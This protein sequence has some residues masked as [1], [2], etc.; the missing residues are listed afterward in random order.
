MGVCW[1]GGAVGVLTI[2]VGEGG[3]G[4]TSGFCSLD[5]VPLVSCSSVFASAVF[6]SLV[7]I[8]GHG[9]YTQVRRRVWAVVVSLHCMRISPAHA[10]RSQWVCTARTV[11]CVR[12]VSQLC[13]DMLHS[14]I[15]LDAI[16]LR[17]HGALGTARLSVGSWIG[18]DSGRVEQGRLG[19][20]G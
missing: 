3:A 18:L 7:S 6:C 13:A 1:R 11:H 8:C 19:G 12:T 14:A 15:C 4:R 10:Q 17:G 9:A 20:E 2:G 16:V 5:F